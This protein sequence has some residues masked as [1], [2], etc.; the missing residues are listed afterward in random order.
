MPGLIDRPLWEAALGMAGWHGGP[1]PGHVPRGSGELILASCDRETLV[2]SRDHAMIILIVRLGLR[3]GEV[4]AVERVVDFVEIAACN[5]ETDIRRPVPGRNQPAADRQPIALQNRVVDGPSAGPERL[6]EPP[7]DG[8]VLRE[9]RGLP[10]VF[11]L[12]RGKRARVRARSK[13]AR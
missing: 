10:A 6:L 8:A 4:A 9:R 13:R 1:L 3:A 2:G 7:A 11:L 12:A 5:R